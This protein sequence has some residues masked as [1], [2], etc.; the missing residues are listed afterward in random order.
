MI[1]VFDVDLARGERADVVFPDDAAE[2]IIV[3]GPDVIAVKI[4]QQRS[5]MQPDSSRLVPRLSVLLESIRRGRAPAVRRIV[6]LQE[7][8]IMRKIVIVDVGGVLDV[9]E[10]EVFP[11]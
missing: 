7:Q 2:K 1:R 4:A 9:V 5:V 6:Q 3:P 11:G 10:R 8:L